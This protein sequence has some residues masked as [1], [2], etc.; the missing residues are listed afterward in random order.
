[1]T[2]A[3]PF[4]S[5]AILSL[6]GVNCV[7]QN[8]WNC[9][10]KHNKEK[11]VKIFEGNLDNGGSIQLHWFL[12]HLGNILPKYFQLNCFVSASID[13]NKSIGNALRSS[14]HAKAE[15]NTE[16]DLPAENI[17]TEVAPTPLDVIVSDN[18]VL[19]GV[20]YFILNPVK[21]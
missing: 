8:Q 6:A 21:A 15:N 3:F 1:M 16:Q 5:A 14:L 11:F 9:K 10:L 20:P 12:K 18:T 7:I 13:N 4:E 17:P 19:Y 2:F